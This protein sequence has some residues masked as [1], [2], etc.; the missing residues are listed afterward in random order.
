M[1]QRITCIFGILVGI[2]FS[3]PVLA[4]SEKVR[5]IT[6]PLKLEFPWDMVSMDF[7]GGTFPD[8]LKVKLGNED[9]PAQV[10]RLEQ[11]G[12]KIDRV[13]FFASLSAKTP[14]VDV[15]FSPG[16]ASTPLKLSHESGHYVVNNGISTIKIVDYAGHRVTGRKFK[17]VPHWLGGVKVGDGPW[18]GRAWFEGIS[19]VRNAKTTIL[20]KG[21]VFIDFKIEYDFED[22]RSDGTVL[23][24]PPELGKQTFRRPPGDLPRETIEKKSHHYEVLIRVAMNDPWIEIVERYRLPKLASMNDFGV[25]QYF[26]HFGTP[27]ERTPPGLIEAQQHFSVD[28]VMWT[29]WF[30]WDS[31]GGNN[32]LQFV[33]AKPRPTQKG[34]PFAILRSR[35]NQGGGGAQDFFLT[36][37]GKEANPRSPTVGIVAAY[38]SKWVG[39]YSASMFAYAYDGNRGEIRFPLTDGTGSDSSSDQ[40][41]QWYGNRCYALCVGPRE[42]FDST[43]KLDSLVRRHTDWTLNAQVNKYVLE[44]TRDPSVAGANIL[45]SR[46]RLEQIRREWQQKSDT[47][48]VRLLKEASQR[49]QTERK[50]LESMDPNSKEFKDLSRKLNSDSDY[51]LLSFLEGLSVSRPPQPNPDQYL[52]RRYQADDVNPTNYGTRRLINGV[53]PEADLYSIDQPFGNARTAAIGY[54]CTDLDAWPGYRNGWGPGNPNFHTD[55]YI[56]A[57]FAAAAMRDHPHSREWFDYGKQQFEDDVRRVITAPDGVGYECPGYSGYSLGLQTELAGVFYNAGM[58]N[59]IAQNPLIKSSTIW[60]RKLLTPFDRRLNRRHEAPHGDTHRWDGGIGIDNWAKLA[61]FYSETDPQHGSELMGVFR[62]LAGKSWKPKSLRSAVFEMDLDQPVTP[63]EKM[64]WSSQYFH[65]FGPIFRNQ[66]GTERESFLSMKAGWTYGHYHN[67][68]LAFHYYNH[69]TPIAL[70][71]NCSY[72]PRGDHA[73]LHNSMT[74]GKE[75]KVRHNARGQDVDAAEQIFGPGRVGV[76]VSTPQADLVV[77]ERS[78][79]RLT[80][81]PVE[82]DDAEFSRNYESRHV[83]PIVH[84]RWLAM[85]RHEAGSALSDYLVVRDETQSREPQQINLH[86]LARDARIESETVRLTGQWDQDMIVRVVESTDL[87]IQKRYWAYFDEWAAFPE[88]IV[89]REGETDTQWSERVQKVASDWKFQTVQR[90]Q[91][92]ENRNRW[93]QAIDQTQGRAMMPP[94]D[95][96]RPWLYGES[97]IWLRISTQPGSPTTWVLYPYKR[98]TP[99]PII[100][101]SEDGRVSIRIG[102]TIE[103]IQ[104]GSEFGMSVERNGVKTILLP[105]NRLPPMGQFPEEA[106][107]VNQTRLE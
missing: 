95:W 8:D 94:P 62:M 92:P 18:D 31:F 81:S 51:R 101:R 11:E 69:N 26:I 41:P 42:L 12:K 57:I 76:F 106:P 70:D 58:G 103:T 52:S 7:P 104:I 63:P 74:F 27:S 99:E 79:D 30:E 45:T 56:G 22:S 97:Q 2:V 19:V 34:R 48:R 59:L 91:L 86:L 21:P 72:H 4:E 5:T 10:E 64:D 105:P 37:G 71:Y 32:Q 36:S 43:P 15:Y 87:E 23:S 60:H 83:D 68:E 90:E 38:P 85:I 98:G 14:S 78:S 55:K 28:T 9:R 16:Q 89:A 88:E 100:T 44:W 33:E 1:K 73:A 80:L 49:F 82:P 53:F 54:I 13:W 25:H 75:G 93:K 50:K 65:G 20:N 39:P 66:F 67:D 96:N 17:D 3:F 102:D 40:D 61:L 84:R 46:K 47:A 6:N 24:Q 35:W 77:A 107:L 29:R